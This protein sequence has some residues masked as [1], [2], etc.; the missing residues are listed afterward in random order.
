MA[1]VTVKKESS[2]MISIERVA[3]L[4]RLVGTD[5]LLDLFL[6][7]K[8]AAL[9]NMAKP[10]E[11]PIKTMAAAIVQ[12]VNIWTKKDKLPLPSVNHVKRELSAMK[13]AML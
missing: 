4:A 13:R 11:P 9:A 3:Q 6:L 8:N 12:L 7:A 1:V 10:V 2:R 5:H